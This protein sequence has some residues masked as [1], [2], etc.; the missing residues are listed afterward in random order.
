MD[1]LSI[2]WRR[3]RRSQIVPE[4]NQYP[5]TPAVIEYYPAWQTSFT[6]TKNATDRRSLNVELNT[7]PATPLVNVYPAWLVSFNRTSNKTNRKL[8]QAPSNPA[9]PLT[10]PYIAWVT[11]YTV[12]KNAT[13]RRL[14]TDLEIDNYPATPAGYY[15]GYFPGSKISKSNRTVYKRRLQSVLEL[16]TYPATPAPGQPITGWIT[17]FEQTSNKTNRRLLGVELNQYPVTPIAPVAD[18]YAGAQLITAYRISFKQ[19]IQRVA[20]LNTRPLAASPATLPAFELWPTYKHKSS[21]KL[22]EVLEINEYPE[23]PPE[24]PAERVGS[25][26]AAKHVR[27]AMRRGR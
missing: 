23:T 18:Y 7:Y 12:T 4:H 2:R 26:L 8:Q 14:I 25:M 22:L 17:H 19:D 15:S 1:L 24:I 16:N 3:P 20:E 10:P 21:Y 5:T 27:K 9:H 13:N 11:D 6:Q